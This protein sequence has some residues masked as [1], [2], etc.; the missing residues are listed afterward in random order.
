LAVEFFQRTLLPFGIVALLASFIALWFWRARM[1]MLVRV[2]VLSVGVFVGSALV[3]ALLAL[4]QL[5]WLLACLDCL[6]SSPWYSI[7]FTF[8]DGWGFGSLV[9]L[10]VWHYHARRKALAV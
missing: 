8:L 7:S 6:A 3:V 9:A 4:H 1:T 5:P 2:I 10:L